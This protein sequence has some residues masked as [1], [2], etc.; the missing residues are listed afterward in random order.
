VLNL[1]SNVR[2]AGSHLPDTDGQQHRLRT[3]GGN[4]A[5]FQE[6]EWGGGYLQR[7]ECASLFRPEKSSMYSTASM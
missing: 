4:A 7:S 3:D 5:C 6:K 2:S 1:V